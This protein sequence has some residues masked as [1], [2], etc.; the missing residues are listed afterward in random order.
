[1]T[2]VA[3]AGCLFE[4]HLDRDPGG[5]H[6]RWVDDGGGVTLVGAHSDTDAP[7]RCRWR[8]RAEREGETTLRFTGP[9]GQTAAAMVR[10]APESG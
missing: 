8:F 3:V 7:D 10:I 1:M 9:D 2:L 6:W 5:G 4:I